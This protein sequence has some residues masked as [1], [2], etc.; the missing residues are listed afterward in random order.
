MERSAEGGS[1]CAES[2]AAILGAGEATIRCR[3]SD[4]GAGAGR[5]ERRSAPGGTRGVRRPRLAPLRGCGSPPRVTPERSATKTAGG[6]GLVILALGVVFGDIGTSPLYAFETA[7]AIAGADAAIGVAS[8]ICWTLLLV[9]GLKYVLLVMRADYHGEGGI[10]AL[11]ALFF[12]GKPKQP[13]DRR[14]MAVLLIFGAALLFGDGAITPAISVLSAIEGLG[15]LDPAWSRFS[16][17]ISV[18][19]LAGLFLVQRFGT[20]RLGSFFGPV[21]LLWFLALGTL[22]AIEVIR[23]PSVLAALDPRHG[24]ALLLSGGWMAWAIVGAVVLAV[25]G[26]EALYAD[27]GHFGR[28][29]IVRA[30]RLVVFPALLLN[31][32]GQ[33]AF[34]LRHPEHALDENL[35]FLLAPDAAWRAPLVVL[36]TLATIIASQALISGVFSLASQAMDLGYLPRMRVRYTSASSRGQIHIPVINALLGAICIALVLGFRS[37]EALAA[38]Y[39]IAVTGAMAITS[40]AYVRVMNRRRSVSWWISGPLLAGL[41]VVDLSL[42]GA[43]LTKIADGGAVPILIA[44]AATTTMLVWRKGRDL[45]RQS[46]TGEIRTPASLAARLSREPITRVPGSVAFVVRLGDVE[47]ASARVLEHCRHTHVL[48]ENAIILLLDPE[49]S[50]PYATASNVRVERFEEGLWVVEANHGYMVEPDAPAML[51]EA[52]RLFAASGGQSK[53]D[54]PAVDPAGTIYVVAQEVVLTSTRR[55][56]PRWQRFLFGFMARNALPGPDYLNIPPDRLIV[57]T[58]LRRLAKQPRPADL[59]PEAPA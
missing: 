17:P 27:L 46:L 1:P 44:A 42:F 20:G 29:P 33:A 14:L 45:V 35:F 36:A 55:Q 26:A 56:M 43:C 19:I 24:A 58:W 53:G 28:L 22:G 34:A 32:L 8:L 18:A 3:E 25:T 48:A 50:D 40:I 39:G 37:S 2:P 38:A 49:W 47:Y 11:M 31:Y 52:M 54:R 59:V 21:M 12:G 7:L 5:G 15:T 30:W 13:E 10:L 51:A 41:L 9:V 57:Y 4:Q 23:M 6:A 16:V